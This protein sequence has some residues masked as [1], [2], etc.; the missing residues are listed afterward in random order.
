MTNVTSAPPKHRSVL[1]AFLDTS[2][3]GSNE[4]VA[5][6]GADSAIRVLSVVVVNGATANTVKF[7]SAANNKTSLFALGIN[8]GIVLPFTEH[9]WFQCNAGEALNINLSGATA[10]G[11]TVN[12]MVL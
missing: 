9:G 7:M 8:G 4:V 6:P 11:V 3:S 12:Y 2:T 5:A 10:V 1:T